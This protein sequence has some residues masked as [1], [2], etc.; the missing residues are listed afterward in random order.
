MID[1]DR[2][3]CS[4]NHGGDECS[5]NAHTSIQS[6][7]EALRTMIYEYIKTGPVTCEEIEMALGLKHQTASARVSELKALNMVRPSGI[8]RVTSS[9]RKAHVLEIICES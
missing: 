5:V 6:S 8:K 2:D 7:K 1:I 4:N 3:I 9:G